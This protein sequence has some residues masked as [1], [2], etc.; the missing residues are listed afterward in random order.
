MAAIHVVAQENGLLKSLVDAVAE[1]L[2][3]W[4]KAHPDDKVF[5]VRIWIISKTF[6]VRD[7]EAFA[8][9]LL[10]PAPA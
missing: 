3:A 9:M 6:Y 8:E 7:L 5:T 2:W 4:I 1:G 10:G